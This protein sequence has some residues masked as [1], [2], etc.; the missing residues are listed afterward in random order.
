MGIIVAGAWGLAGGGAA[1]LVSLSADV[2]AAGHTW[3]WRDNPYGIWPRLFVIVVGMIIGAVVAGAAHSQMTG[4]WPALLTGISAPTIIRGALSR[5]AVE[6][7]RAVP[8]PPVEKA[9]EHAV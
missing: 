3:P 6:S 9:E 5:G 8:L 7:N 1:G 2:V 4:P